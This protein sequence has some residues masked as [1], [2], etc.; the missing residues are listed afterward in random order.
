MIIAR[1]DATDE[2]KALIDN[3]ANKQGITGEYLVIDELP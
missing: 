2:W 1:H 3:A